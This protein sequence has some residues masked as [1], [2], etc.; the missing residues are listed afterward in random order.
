MKHYSVFSLV[1]GCLLVLGAAAAQTPAGSALPRL[2]RFSGIAKDPG[3]NP[4][5]GVAG[6]TFALYAEQ[7]GGAPL[8]SETQN[9]QAGRDGHYTVLLG[10]A[11]SEGLPADLFTAEQAHW[12]GVSV[13]GQAEQPRILL[14]SAPYALK[15]GDA[16][17][18]GGLPPSAFLLAAPAGASVAKPQ[19]TPGASPDATCAA[20]TSDGTATANQVAKFT[21]ACAIEPSAIFESGGNVGIGTTAPTAALDVNGNAVVT[22][23]ISATGAA[24]LAGVSLPALETATASAGS[25]SNSL[26][27]IASSYKSTTA[28]A[29]GE[30]FTW[31]AEPVGND[32]GSPSGSLNLLF[33]TDKKTPVET[34]LSL[35]SNGQIAFAS[36]QTFPGTGTIT[37][38]TAGPG[39]T[40]GGTSGTVTVGLTNTCANGQVLE[41]SG[42]A[43]ACAGV[44]TGTITGVTAGTDLTGGGASGNVTLNLNT[45]KT[46]ARY[47]QLGASNSFSGLQSITGSS[48]SQTLTVTQTGTGATGDGI[49]GI[50]SATGGT[51]VFGE[52]AIAIQGYANTGGLAGLFRGATEVNGNGN[53]TVIGDPGCGSG[54]AGIGFINATL[55]GCTNY[56]VIGGAA[57]DTYVNSSGTAS[58][59]FRSNNNELAT[60]DNLGNVNV[61]GQNGGGNLTVA[62]TLSAGGSLPASSQDVGV[63]GVAAGPSGMDGGEA[64]VWG[65]TGGAGY[66]GV[67]GTSFIGFAGA[68]LNNSNTSP[69]LYA[70]NQSG[71]DSAVFQALG[72][73][74]AGCTIFANG[75]LTCSGT[76]A[77]VVPAG[78]QKVSVYAMQS[79]E[80]WFEDTGSGQLSSGSAHVALDPTFAQTVNTSV[81]YH[82]FLT[83]RG[84]CQGLYVG[85]QT[86][87]GFEVHELRGGS[88]NIA[89]DYRIMAKRNG[90]ETVRLADVTE[91]YQETERQQKALHERTAQR[92]AVSPKS[93][94]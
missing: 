28:A 70:S 57:G 51:G 16:E 69:A 32:T 34:G 40:G 36:G 61:I 19:A 62:Q 52:G 38:V 30:R 33:N 14:V 43:W 12:V 85:N 9:V 49:H 27:M 50:T 89:F 13:E 83:P 48:S 31:Q 39:L 29:I 76:I 88:S 37:G 93:Q 78:A 53:N 74:A 92:R 22:G 11:K 68:F 94:H 58:I 45:S 67:Q 56:A 5:T 86:A 10:A 2:V 80:N 81:E 71:G 55:A 54:Y 42:S 91:K 21:A 18:L 75:N 1:A 64:G 63:Y 7:T 44:G 87:Q 20:I 72:P 6:I 47:A 41:W 24:T 46:D 79:T 35:A 4:V 17:T 23:S 59:H 3:G 25:N 26:Q 84:D 66:A 65:D 60:I 8:W 77:G 15:A 90:F 73:G 82:V